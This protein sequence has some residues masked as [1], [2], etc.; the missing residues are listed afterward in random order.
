MMVPGTKL[1]PVEI[2]LV[3]DNPVDVMMTREAICQRTNMQQP[4]RG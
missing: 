1:Q 4:S 3:E 2:L